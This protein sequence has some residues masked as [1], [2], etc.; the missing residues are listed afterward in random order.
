M[1]SAQLCWMCGKNE[2]RRL[3]ARVRRSEDRWLVCNE[4]AFEMLHAAAVV[5]MWV[6][7]GDATLVQ[8]DLTIFRGGQHV[9]CTL[10]V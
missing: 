6:D 8:N 5:G 3:L 4:C 7:V 10:P 1:T 9:H 2:F